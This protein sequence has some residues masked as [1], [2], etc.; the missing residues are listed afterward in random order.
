MLRAAQLRF[1]CGTPFRPASSLSGCAPGSLKGNGVVAIRRE[2]KNRWERR[3]PLDPSNVRTL[4]RRGIKVVVQPSTMRFFTNE[5]YVKAGAVLQEDISVASVILGVKEVPI[6]LLIPERTLMCFSHTIKAQEPNMPLLDAILNKNIRLI[7]YECMVDARGK[8]VVGFGKFAGNAGMIDLLRGLGDRLLGLGYSSPFLGMGYTDYYHSLSAS[9]TAIQLVGHSIMVNGVP[10]DHAPFIFAFT[11]E[12]SVTQG[13]LEIFRELPH[14]FI[15]PS[16]LEEVVGSGDSRTCYGVMLKREHLAQPIDPS[17]AFNKEHYTEHPEEYRPVFHEKVAPYITALVN[18]MYWDA[19]FPKLL[20]QPQMQQLMRDGSRMLAIADISADPYGSIEF[21]KVCTQIDRPFLVYNPEDDT[22]IYNW[23]AP[24]I[25]L[26]SVDNLPAQ[27]PKEASNHFG[28]LLLPYIAKLAQSDG[29]VDFSQQTDIPDTLRNAIITSQGKLTP[30]FEYIQTLREEKE[31]TRLGKEK[32]VLVCGSGMV[33]AP[34]VEYLKSCDLDISITIASAD[35][36]QA[37]ALAKKYNCTAAELNVEDP[38]LLERAVSNNHAVISLVPASLHARIAQACIK[39]G[40]NMV[41]TSYISPEMQALDQSAKDAGVTILNEIGLD[42]G[43]DHLSAMQMFDQVAEHGGKL[44]V[45]VSY[46]GGLPAPEFSNNPLGYKF[47][48]SPRGVLS[49]GQNAARW[50]ENNKVIETKRGELF[51]HARPVDIFPALSLEGLP[52]RDSL[53]YEPLYGLDAPTTMMRGTLRFKGFSAVMCALQ[54]LGMFSEKLLPEL[55]P[56][57]P[58]LTWND[59]MNGV[60]NRNTGNLFFLEEAVKRRVL[61]LGIF[62]DAPVNKKGTVIDSFC[63]LLKDRLAYKPHESDLVLLTH[64]FGIVWKDG[65]KE[66]RRST[67]YKVGDPNGHTAMATTVGLP[68]AIAVEHLLGGHI[69]ATGVL[70]P[71]QK[72]LYNHILRQLAKHNV[73]LHEESFFE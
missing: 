37:Q 70:R 11:G 19:R 30:R 33:V 47:S 14:E 63:E 57:A 43:I 16:E 73:L 7:D 67:L 55:A 35:F 49:A 53:A 21:T 9:K 46:C 56:D 1:Q 44:D 17:Q 22:E 54:E 41:T 61:G 27:M 26:G 24:G 38:A 59:L 42:P 34:C 65:R 48:W 39:L 40:V 51:K 4:V 10:A 72:D 68:C 31:H 58:A 23:E 25:L 36:S 29:S 62:S 32:Q 66:T 3:A 18:G 60:L 2:T 69:K 20:T 15:D 45:F 8:R 13:A 28:H 52:N 64:E 50:R 71:L 6:D 12:G 5:E